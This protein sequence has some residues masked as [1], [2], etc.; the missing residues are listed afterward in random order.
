MLPRHNGSLSD[1]VRNCDIQP[2]QLYSANRFALIACY[3]WSW[4]NGGIHIGAVQFN[5]LLTQGPI[6]LSYEMHV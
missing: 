4:R 5:E 2:Y 1:F 3:L 6:L